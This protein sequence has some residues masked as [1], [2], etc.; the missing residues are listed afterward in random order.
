MSFFQKRDF[1]PGMWPALKAFDRARVEEDGA[2]R[3]DGF[4]HLVERDEVGRPGR[5][6]LGRCRHRL[7]PGGHGTLFGRPALEAAVED[8]DLLHAGHAEDR[9]DVR[10]INVAFFGVHDDGDVARDSQAVDDEVDRL[11]RK[12]SAGDAAG[13]RPEAVDDDGL[14]AGQM[15][16]EIR[17]D[18]GARIQEHDAP[19]RG[20]EAVR[21]SRRRDD[22]REKVR[23]GRGRRE[24]EDEDDREGAD[25][26]CA[27]TS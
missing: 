1:A 22:R 8:R 19:G 26:I 15:A 24:G 25:S 3:L 11:P 5:E 6:G 4:L 17:L 16:R 18:R 14:R 12:E 23:R 20:R 10:R 9:R 7:A 21:E 2:L 13:R 27:E